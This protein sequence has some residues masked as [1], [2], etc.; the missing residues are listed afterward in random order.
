MPGINPH[1]QI[2]GQ[3]MACILAG[4]IFTARPSDAIALAELNFHMRLFFHLTS[5]TRATP[6]LVSP[7]QSITFERETL[8]DETESISGS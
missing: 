5:T 6:H 3:P 4:V 8:A 2:A 7:Y 1:R